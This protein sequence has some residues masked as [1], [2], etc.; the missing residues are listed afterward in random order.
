MTGDK[1][2]FKEV[3]KI[4]GGSVKFGDDSK[5]KIVGTSIVPFNNNCYITEVYLVDG[6]NYNL[7]SISQLG[8]SGEL[9]SIKQDVPLKM[10][11]VKSFFQ[12]K[13]MEMF[14]FLIAL[15]I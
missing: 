9:I 11:Q 1:Y 3:T 2:L 7:L 8:D 13:G 14:T 12:V 10:S 4:S 5:G 15:E 6:L